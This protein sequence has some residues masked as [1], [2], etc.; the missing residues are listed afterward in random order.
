[1]QEQKDLANT[2]VNNSYWGMSCFDPLGT[3]LRATTGI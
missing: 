1:M 2:E 3:G